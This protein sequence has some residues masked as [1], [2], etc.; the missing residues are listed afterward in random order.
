M[1]EIMERWV[2][3]LSRSL[4]QEFRCGTSFV[5]QKPHC[6]GVELSANDEFI[7]KQQDA[8]ECGRQHLKVNKTI[9]PEWSR[10]R[11]SKHHIQRHWIH[12]E[13]MKGVRAEDERRHEHD[14]L[15]PHPFMEWMCEKYKHRILWKW[16]QTSHQQRLQMFCEWPERQ[17]KLHGDG[18]VEN[19]V[20]AH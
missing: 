10:S 9:A 11:N 1:A 19:C 5:C 2:E 15:H 13:L 4:Y 8:W 7:W 14:W 6:S 16:N 12:I 3:V 18:I 17:S 20:N